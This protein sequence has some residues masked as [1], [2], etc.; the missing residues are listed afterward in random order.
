MTGLLNPATIAIAGVT[1]AAGAVAAGLISATKESLAFHESFAD[2]AV[3]GLTATQL[4][5]VKESS[6]DW[7]A[8]SGEDL[9][10]VAE[11]TYALQSA[12][13]DFT[14]TAESMGIAAKAAAA[15]NT[16]LAATAEL[17]GAAMNAYGLEGGAAFQSIMDMSVTAANLSSSNFD[18]MAKAMTGVL[19]A[20]ADMGIGMDETMAAVV[21]LTKS[22]ETASE[23]VTKVNSIMNAFYKPNAEMMDS[24]KSIVADMDE[25]G[26]FDEHAD[27]AV[28]QRYK[29]IEAI[30]NTMEV[31]GGKLT[32]DQAAV[33][34]EITKWATSDAEAATQF[35]KAFGQASADMSEFIIA[36]NGMVGL[37]GALAEEAD[38]S[39]AA[40]AGMLGNKEAIDGF[41]TLTGEFADEWADATEQI[42]AADGAVEAA[43][44]TYVDNNPAKGL[45]DV[46]A[47]W[48]EM[49]VLIGDTLIPLFTKGMELLTPLMET[50]IVFLRDMDL[51]FASE[52]ES[53]SGFIDAVKGIATYLADTFKPIWDAYIGNFERVQGVIE[54][55]GVLDAFADIGEALGTL[56]AAFATD[57]GD[58][59]LSSYIDVLAGSLDLLFTGMSV[60]IGFLL[61]GLVLLLEQLGVFVV[62]LTDNVPDALAG[63]S[64]VM[65]EVGDNIELAL[66]DPIAALT[67]LWE[68]FV[69]WLTEGIE[70]DGIGD[71]IL[72]GLGL[73]FTSQQES[74]TGFMDVVKGIATY[75]TDTFKPIWDALVANFEQVEG[76][77]E[78]SG[79][80]VTFTE[81]GEAFATLFA[82]FAT[83]EVKDALSA[84][85]QVFAELGDAFKTL[86]VDLGEGFGKMFAAF[87]TD[88]GGEGISSYIDVFAKSLE[89]LFTGLS[90]LLGFLLDGLVLL[91]DQF[92]IFIVWLAEH[93]PAALTAFAQIMGHV[94]AFIKMAMT[95]PIAALTM[96]WEGFARWLTEGISW[97]GIGRCD[98][99]GCSYRFFSGKG[100]PQ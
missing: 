10:A 90:I 41:V 51:N 67:L 28:Y 36:D 61:D 9:E 65:E 71:A 63:F 2:L 84:Y 15:G 77:I 46:K 42:G 32:E 31:E 45:D 72:D 92:A 20:A 73:D 78:D 85:V 94:G 33:Y 83:D 16:E 19:P 70:W 79:I 40:I 23:A 21:A 12:T 47:K 53:I 7:A 37:L 62:W 57:E 44:K 1:A 14:T 76:V 81:L 29:D 97:S 98:T 25:L 52:E 54:D 86:F 18:E 75:L 30:Y 56:F 74:I 99:P 58:E 96:L 8:T 24:M 68:G 100:V 82:A 69:D 95:D 66:T 11:A 35:E 27:E 43:Y 6:F 80:F 64:E 60:M 4:E 93:L 39:K 22:G 34:A 38:G 3:L 26:K 13:Q 55:S 59:A 17:G 50:A 89:L 49:K 91:I 87:A 5:E 48:T 88:E